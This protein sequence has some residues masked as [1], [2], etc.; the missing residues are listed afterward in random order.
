MLAAAVFVR[1]IIAHAQPPD[2]LVTI[3]TSG[4][5]TNV[6]AGL[7]EGRRRGLLTIALA[8]YDGGEIARQNLADFCIVVPSDYI[9]RIQE[10]HA[11]VYH[12]M[13][14]LIAGQAA[15]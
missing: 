11:S 12:V 4:A 13:S 14:D 9:P 3:T 6:I 8:G 7:V 1:Q 5:S 15:A 10:V 2:V